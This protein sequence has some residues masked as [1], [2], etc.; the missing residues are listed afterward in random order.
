[1]ASGENNVVPVDKMESED[2]T[3]SYHVGLNVHKWIGVVFTICCYAGD[4][5][6][7][8]GRLS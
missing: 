6:R 5:N 3:D 1:M 2:T 8:Q 7:T 4:Q